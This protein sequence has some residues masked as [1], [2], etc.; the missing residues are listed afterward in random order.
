MDLTEDKLKKEV[1][2][3]V[4]S[5]QRLLPKKK[6]II[7]IAP[8]ILKLTRLNDVH[9]EAKSVFPKCFLGA[10]L[11]ILRE[12][13]DKVKLIQQYNYGT[14]KE[15]YKCFIP[16]LHNEMQPKNSSDG[17]LIDSAGCATATYTDVLEGAYVMRLTS[18]IKDLISSETELVF[19]KDNEKSLGSVSCVMKDVDPN[20][21]RVVTQWMYRIRSDFSIGT[22]VGLKPLAYPPVPE[23]SLSARYEQPS[24]T[25]SSTVCKSGFQVCLYKKF[26]PDLRIAA[27]V[28]DGNRG[29]TTSVGVA[30]HKSCRNSS[31]MKVFV[32]SM[33]CGGFTFQKDIL[34]YEPQE[35]N[36]VRVLRL[37]GSTLIDRQ[38]RVRFGLGFNLDF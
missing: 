11:V 20:S 16:L 5:L 31:E 17:L 38:R 2:S 15:N 32:D 8:Q 9:A 10:K 7:V 36:E 18:K 6:D 12:I 33:R 25:I 21:M 1:S 13:M 28:H 22:E 4:S 24:F 14:S 26:S 23:Y 29:G 30:V 34:F 3:F 37:I 35:S 27:V 19:E